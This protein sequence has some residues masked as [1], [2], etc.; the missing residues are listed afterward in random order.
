MNRARRL[1]S[2]DRRDVKRVI[3]Q[4]CIRHGVSAHDEDYRSIG[5]TTFL[6]AFRRFHAVSSPDF[7]PYACR[8]I[9]AAIFAEK[10]V[11]QDR[12]YHLLSLHAPAAPDSRE[13]CLSRLPARR[14]DF[15][16]SVLLWDFLGR[17][18]RE[19]T[20]LAGRLANG[21]SLEEARSILGMTEQELCHA[22]D[23]L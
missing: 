20:R 18:P 16:N 9:S 8:Q 11:R 2:Q 15:T 17:L 12:M 10:Q 4:R 1:T 6:T 13:T 19:L 21:D 7:W 5:W 22:V 14:G 23:R 3:S